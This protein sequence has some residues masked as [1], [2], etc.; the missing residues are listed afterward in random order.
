MT[1]KYGLVL[2]VAAVALAGPAAHA[3]VGVQA[4]ILTCIEG[5]GWGFIIGS[6]RTLDCVFSGTGEHYAGT[7]NKFGLDIGY[8]SQGT[9]IWDVFAPTASVGPGGLAGHYAG[10]T[11]SA[12]AGVGAGAHALIGGSN[13]QVA[14]QPLSVEGNS[15]FNLAAGVAE[16]AL[17]PV[18]APPPAPL[19]RP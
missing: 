8:I 12:S 7:I 5:A 10:G 9:I 11:F 15:G 3:E 16:I 6:S 13:Q 4:G 2:A 1:Q 17:E 14:L 19:P 18:A